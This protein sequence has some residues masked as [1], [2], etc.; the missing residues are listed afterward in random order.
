MSAE[1][2]RQQLRFGMLTPEEV[3]RRSGG[4]VVRAGLR[5]ATGE[6]VEGGLL[7]PRIFGPPGSEARRER[8]GHVVLA[9]PVVHPRLLGLRP[10]PLALLLGLRAGEVARLLRG[11]VFVRHRPDWN[12]ETR[13]WLVESASVDAGTRLLT[14]AEALESLLRSLDLSGLEAWLGAELKRARR[15]AK[16][17]WLARRLGLV[18]G[19]RTS[20]V[21]PVAMVLRVLPVLP[22]ERRLRCN[23]LYLRVLAR[24]EAVRALPPRPEGAPLPPEYKALQRA[25]AALFARLAGTVKRRL[26]REVL[27]GREDFSAR[28]PLAPDPALRLDECRLPV[29]LA[30]SLCG[31]LL[32]VHLKETGAAR[33]PTEARALIS[34]RHPEALRALEVLLRDAPLVVAREDV[35]S[36]LDV[37]SL[38]L[39]LGEGQA[40]GCHPALFERLGDGGHNAVRLSLPLTA[41]A[42]SEVRRALSVRRHVFSHF[43][44]EPLHVPTQE[45]LHGL[46]YATHARAGARGEGRLFANADEAALAF[47]LGQV[48]LQ[49]AITV[50]MEEHGRRSRVS[51]T[52][53]RVLLFRELEGHVPFTRVNQTLHRQAV[54]DLL[55]PAFQDSGLHAATVLTERLWRWGLAHA[56]S[57]GLSLAARDVRPP[58]DKARLVAD[59]ERE[60]G[61]LELRYLEGHLTDGERYN[62]VLGAWSEATEAV[63]RALREDLRAGGPLAD[64]MASGAVADTASV[65]R[66]M[67]MQ[68]LV[69]APSGERFEQPIRASLHEGR[70]SH[71]FFLAAYG[72]RGAHAASLAWE[73]QSRNLQRWLVGALGPVQVTR[74][75]CG[76]R[77]GIEVGAQVRDHRIIVDVAARITG[78]TAAEDLWSP[79]GQLRL[80]RAGETLDAD[81]AAR[82]QRWGFYRVRVRSVLTCEAREGVCA[83]CLGADPSSLRSASMGEAVG[84]RAASLFRFL[85]RPPKP[86]R[87]WIGS[88]CYSRTP[89]FSHDALASVPGVV[90]YERLQ[91]EP[92]V[93]PDTGGPGLNFVMLGEEGRLVVE[94]DSGAVLKS[95]RVRRGDWIHCEDG[96]RVEADTHL[97]S[98]VNPEVELVVADLPEGT[99][100]RVLDFESFP[101]VEILGAD[102]SSRGIMAAQVSGAVSVRVRPGDRVL[103]G[104]VLATVSEPLPSLDPYDLDADSLEPLLRARRPPSRRRAR[105]AEAEGLVHE[106]RTEGRSKNSTRKRLLLYP[107]SGGAPRVYPVRP[108]AWLSYN[109][110]GRKPR[111]VQVG[112]Q[113]IDGDESFHDVLHLF[114]EQ[115]AAERLI[116]YLERFFERNNAPVRRVD[117][118]LLAR[119]MLM[120]Q[121]L[122]QDGG[123]TELPP[124]ERVPRE[125]ARRLHAEAVQRGGRGATWTPVLTG[126]PALAQE[127]S[128]LHEALFGDAV[129]AWLRAALSG[130]VEPFTSPTVR[131]LAPR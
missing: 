37:V 111:R 59:A 47:E 108:G 14:G 55:I 52:V 54:A 92:R 34:G 13:P 85:A 65:L 104:D 63:T 68:G 120:S 18:R 7:C 22:V 80:A 94:S 82:L 57:A 53:G 29:D 41:R 100:G 43:S 5:D 123:D 127:G 72:A 24:N 33:S 3:L 31:P 21:P 42:R 15:P 46:W 112:E 35:R 71:E 66:L 83:R 99:T 97:V 126:L 17:R 23:A 103:R 119:Q 39:R 117:L 61:E 70:S 26:R 38:E 48:E 56:T 27:G 78:R 11:A 87:I 107:D 115:A 44:G 116:R 9:A 62:Q 98:S 40:V 91:V 113:L 125:T 88:V 1:S 50:R 6:A 36:H 102:G 118:E 12:G 110:S 121:V 93:Y 90:R 129:G 101:S 16:R 10:S 51:T 122:I 58:A 4:E 28:A 49:A 95:F 60:V 96:Q 81:L 114:G 89:Y 74:L 106:V 84:L 75:D 69:E 25:V 2:S 76:T 64:L 86:L 73:R 8:F 19:L 130:D 20:G 128:P 109:A 45:A 77:E 131:S 32:A 67:G 79:D 105:F 124:G 30:F